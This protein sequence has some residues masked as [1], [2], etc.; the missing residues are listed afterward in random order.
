MPQGESDFK[1]K[2]GRNEDRNSKVKVL[3]FTAAA[4]GTKE[5]AQD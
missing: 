2:N 3:Y 4:P 5:C 1:R